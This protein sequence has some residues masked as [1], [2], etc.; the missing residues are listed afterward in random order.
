M[1]SI[2]PSP[3]QHFHAQG[4][5]AL[6][7]TSSAIAALLLDGGHT[8]HSHFKISIPIDDAS[9]CNIAKEDHMDGVIQETKIII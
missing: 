8:A 4:K 6:C 9:T 1:M 2:L 3:E 7:V 5:V